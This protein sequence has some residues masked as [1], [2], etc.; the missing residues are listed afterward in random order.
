MADLRSGY[1]DADPIIIT[2]ISG[3]KVA[4]TADNGTNGSFKVPVIVTRANAAAPTW[5]E[6][7]QAPLSVD[8]AGALRIAGTIQPGNTPNTTPWLVKI[9]DGTN[10]ITGLGA[11]NSTNAT[12]KMPTLG[13]V[14]NAAGPAWTEAKQ[15]PLSADL[16]GFL[17]VAD[18][19]SNI[20]GTVAIAATATTQTVTLGTI[21]TPLPDVGAYQLIWY[22]PATGVTLT[23]ATLRFE[24]TINA[25]VDY[26]YPL[27]KINTPSS[28]AFSTISQAA[29][30]AVTYNGVLTLGVL[31]TVKLILNY[32]GTPSATTAS[33]QLNLYPWS[34]AAD[35]LGAIQQVGYLSTTASTANQTI[36][37]APGTGLKIY[38]TSMEGSN[39]AGTASTCDFKDGSAGTIYYSRYMAASGGGFVTN[40]SGLKG[41]WSLTANNALVVTPSF[42]GQQYFSCNFFCAP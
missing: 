24:D 2:D 19:C 27:N 40:F 4:V 18:D 35:N 30:T 5:T 9:H 7:N 10:A 26:D 1:G 36:I 11:D 29:S 20:T 8:L 33:Y 22:W 32:T 17:R 14:A 39:A 25:T 37:G 38:V 28:G 42:A 3:N 6:G 41:A 12:I 31:K 15:V 23:S 34:A 13:A 21:R 16:G